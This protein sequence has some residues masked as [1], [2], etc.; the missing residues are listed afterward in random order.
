MSNDPDRRGDVVAALSPVLKH[1]ATLD[2][3][4]P[5]SAR[6][7][8]QTAF[9]LDGALGDELRLLATEGLRDGWLC[10]REAG[11]TRFSRVA[12]PESAHGFSIDAVLLSGEGPWHRHLKGEVNCLLA[13][14][15]SP[16]FCGFPP[17]WAVFAPGSSHIPAV[18]GGTMMIFYM[19]PEGAVEWK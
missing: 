19:L 3:A 9:A 17:G 12:K 11:G 14:D 8:L 6:Q 1:I 10:N 13:I 18:K 16:E 2:L 15:G 7:S 5:D 4:D